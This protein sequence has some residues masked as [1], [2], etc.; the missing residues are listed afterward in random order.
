MAM[1]AVGAIGLRSGLIGDSKAFHDVLAKI[2]AFSACNTPVLIERETGAG[3]ELVARA[4]H[5]LS[6]RR[7]GPFVPMSDP[8]L[9]DAGF[10]SLRLQASCGNRGL[11]R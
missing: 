10:L 6:Q 1:E 8:G 4:V 3:K 5:N 7:G 11:C 2:K 9:V